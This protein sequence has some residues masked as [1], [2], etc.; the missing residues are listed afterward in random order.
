MLEIGI[1]Y[2]LASRTVFLLDRKAYSEPVVD[3]TGSELERRD[4]R[5]PGALK[6]TLKDSRVGSPESY[7]ASFARRS[8]PLEVEKYSV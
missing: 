4:R 1:F 3:L 5:F 2:T 7:P 6:P 8:Q